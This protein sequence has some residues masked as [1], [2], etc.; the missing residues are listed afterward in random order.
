MNDKSNIKVSIILPVYNSENY[1]T[2][3]IES[4]INQ[5]FKDFEL[6]LINDGSTDSSGKICNDFCDKDNRIKVI[7]KDNGGICDARNTGLKIAKGEYLAFCDH[8]DIYHHDLLEVSY[9]LGIKYDADIVKF[10]RYTKFIEEEKEI[11]VTQTLFESKF[12]DRNAIKSNYFSFRMNEMFDCVWDSLFRRTL[13]KE[14]SLV[15]NTMYKSGQEDIDFNSNVVSF[16]NSIVSTSKPL[17]DHNLRKGFST[18]SKPNMNK[19]D[20]ISSHP[21]HLEIYINRLGLVLE[22]NKYEYALFFSKEIVGNLLHILRSF[23]N[24]ISRE[25]KLTHLKNFRDQQF[26]YNWIDDLSYLKLGKMAIKFRFKNILYIFFLY[27][28][29]NRKFG[30]L[31]FAA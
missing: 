4:I 1:L 31:K 23:G 24:S 30:L 26:V 28:F 6:I 19:L 8:D 20:A 22:K 15:F 29:M 11:K 25:E 13:I 18:S 12:Y 21:Q 3:T 27:L 14:H 16:A 7:H 2:N 5:T 17:Y 10:G 9:S